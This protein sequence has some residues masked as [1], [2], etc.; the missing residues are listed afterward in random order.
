MIIGY[1]SRAAPD[2][3]AGIAGLYSALERMRLTSSDT[4][5][6]AAGQVIRDVVES[7]SAPTKTFEDLRADMRDGKVHDPLSRFSE[8]C[9]AELRALHEI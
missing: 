4:V 8:A 6:G 5:I 1:A 7:Y 3:I 2:A 9:R